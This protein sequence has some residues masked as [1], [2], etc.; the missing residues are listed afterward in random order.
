MET[1]YS[2]LEVPESATPEEIKQ[3]HRLLLQVW[4]PDR[5]QHSPKILPKAEQKTKELNAAFDTLSNPSLKQ[6]YDEGL[7]SSRARNE[8]HKYK[9]S[10]KEART[11]RCPNSVCNSVL[12][13]NA[14]TTGIVTCPSCRTTFRYDP[15]RNEKWDVKQPDWHRATE[16]SEEKADPHPKQPAS[17]ATEG[18]KL[19]T[20]ERIAGLAIGLVVAIVVV[21]TTVLMDVSHTSVMTDVKWKLPPMTQVP[22]RA[23]DSTEA[24]SD[25]QKLETQAAQGNAEAQFDLGELYA[26]GVGVQQ[27]YVVARQWW[28]KS[29]AQGFARSQFKL[30]WLYSEGVGVPQDHEL[31]RQWWEK[32]AEN[33]GLPGVPIPDVPIPD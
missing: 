28:E 18:G 27:D 24:A 12:R 7:R 16:K 19:L 26:D 30:G 1:Y 33:L 13:V 15:E 2:I 8:Q 22:E 6:R 10:G 29:A 3:A 17:A 25:L 5:F 4:H 14:T 11:T 32:S 20:P 31:A 9:T 21:L 23:L